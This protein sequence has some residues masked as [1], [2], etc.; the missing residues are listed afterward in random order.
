MLTGGV[1]SK[2]CRRLRPLAI[3][4]LPA[5]MKTIAV[6]TVEVAIPATPKRN[7]KNA[8]TTAPLPLSKP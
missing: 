2:I 7:K 5:A 8:T 6:K 4:C 1:K 3:K